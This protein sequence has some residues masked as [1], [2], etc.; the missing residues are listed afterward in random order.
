MAG[1]QGKHRG[2][3]GK[4]LC[5]GRAM[6]DQ[7]KMNEMTLGMLAV[8]GLVICAVDCFFWMWGGRSGKWRRRFVGSAIQTAGINILALICGTWVWQFAASL[9]PEILSRCM[10]YGGDSTGY[11][12]L[13]RGLFAA[14]SLAVGA[15][16]AWGVGFTSQA[17]ILLT[18]QAVASVA[19]IILGVWNPLP[20]AVEEVFVCLSLK[21]FNWGYLFI[22]AG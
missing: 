9:V 11:K 21:Y 10:G 15:I 6:G 18:C 8:I 17:L 16:L 12:L 22:A 20:A 2:V 1:K 13:R 5:S 4:P 14:G 19:S 3:S 7:I